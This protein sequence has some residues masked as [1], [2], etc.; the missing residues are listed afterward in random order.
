MKAYTIDLTKEYSFLQGGNLQCILGDCPWDGE[1]PD[2]NRPAVIVVPGGGYGMVSKREGEPIAHA[3][4]AKGFQT[5][6]LWYSVAPDAVYPEQ[7]LQLSVAVD[8]VKKNAK[9]MNVNPDEVFVVG[10]SAGGHLTGNLAVEHQNVSAKVGVELDCKP[11]AVGLAYPVISNI[12]GH[13]GS[14]ENLL[15]GYTEE[16][17]EELMKT[18]SLNEAVSENTPPAFIWAT[19][20]D[21]VVPA[22]NSLRYAMAL[23]KYGIQYEL[24]I[25]PFG[26]HGAS[27]GSDEINV[28]VPED[29]KIKGWINDCAKFFRIYTVEKA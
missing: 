9:E 20:Q 11:T 6:I 23:A 3:F 29:Q 27:T 10:F 25:Y 13:Q 24:H 5:F 14:Y 21:N 19:A 15:L 8:Y 17:Q 28:D 18:L 4:L 2:W 16:A 12:N 26:I 7:L 22:D 1:R